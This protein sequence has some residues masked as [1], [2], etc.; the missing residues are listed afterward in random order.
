MDLS[1]QKKNKY[2]SEAR[3]RLGRKMVIDSVFNNGRTTNQFKLDRKGV[4]I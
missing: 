3:T 2:F 4:M 1:S